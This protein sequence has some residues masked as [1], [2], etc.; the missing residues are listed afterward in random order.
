MAGAPAAKEHP[1]AGHRE[2]L[3]ERFLDHGLA[4]FN[5]D[6]VLE[7]L[8]TLATPRQ[9]CK[10][11]AR[12]LLATFGSL[13]K[14]LEAA[15]AELAKI[16]G[17]GPK[18]V[19][20]LK[21]PPAVARRY[22]EDRLI[23]GQVLADADQLADYLLFSMGPLPREVFRV[24]LVDRERR[25]MDSEDL[26][27]GTCD[28]AAVYPREVVARALAA[29]AAGLICAHNHPG[30]SPRPSRDDLAITRRLYFAARSVGL[31]FHDHLIV[32]GGEVRSMDQNGEL[33]GLA[34]EY[35]IL[36]L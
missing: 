24:I 6:E 21:L 17:I 26:F 33:A 31:A 22:L 8:L 3:R 27:F 28:Q 4:R 16:K 25:V 34:A 14:V 15:P 7:L 12:Q 35:E 18:N 32:A 1:G 20:G 13:A 36:N 29:D 9:D 19:L 10:Q 5:D 23:N 30:G 2:R 11:R